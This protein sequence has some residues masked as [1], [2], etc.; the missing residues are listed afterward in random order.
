MQ[1]TS[2]ITPNW[3]TECQDIGAFR[4]P[5]HKPESQTSR[6]GNRFEGLLQK[7]I[8][9][10]HRRADVFIIDLVQTLTRALSET[11]EDSRYVWS[12]SRVCIHRR[13]NPFPPNIPPQGSSR[14]RQLL[15]FSCV[16][17]KVLSNNY[18]TG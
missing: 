12:R 14:L 17:K 13:P 18:D 2:R 3:L 8:Q 16:I 15:P 7:G 5:L 10:I 4:I 6:R 1:N 11:T 9:S